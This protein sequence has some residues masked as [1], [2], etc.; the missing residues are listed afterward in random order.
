ADLPPAWCI[1]RG[2]TRTPALPRSPAGQVDVPVS[3]RAGRG[4]EPGQNLFERRLGRQRQRARAVA[5]LDLMF[6]RPGGSERPTAPVSL[7]VRAQIQRITG[8]CVD[9]PTDHERR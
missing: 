3:A 6:A 1:D 8:T 5:D 9:G 4:P 7:D 2:V